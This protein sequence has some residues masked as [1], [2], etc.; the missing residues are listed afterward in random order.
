MSGIPSPRKV[1][2][3]GGRGTF[4]G[5]IGR[6]LGDGHLQRFRRNLEMEKKPDFVEKPIGLVMQMRTDI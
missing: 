1:N 5:I 4:E 3:G 6:L 2:G